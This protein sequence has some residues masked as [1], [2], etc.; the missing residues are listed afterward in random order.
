MD[1]SK[2]EEKKLFYKHGMTKDKQAVF[3]Y[4]ARKLEKSFTQDQLIFHIMK[5]LQ[6]ELGKPFVV[7]IDCTLFSKEFEITP[8]WISRFRQVAPSFENLVNLFFINA[9]YEFKKYSKKIASILSL[10]FS[11]ALFL[12]LIFPSVD[13]YGYLTPLQS[14][15]R[16]L[17]LKWYSYR[18][19]KSS[20]SIYQKRILASLLLPV[21]RRRT[22][23][24]YA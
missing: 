14:L 13:E 11:N 4:V 19:L 12:S 15:Y 1:T 5:T 21:S 2:I 7:V 18:V 24:M 8:A 3:Y 20:S 6:P 17:V 10:S 23:V 22:L 9:N 16:V